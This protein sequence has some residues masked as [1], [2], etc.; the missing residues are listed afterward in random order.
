MSV[1]S[2]SGRNRA[3]RLASSSVPPIG[4]FTRAGWVKVLNAMDTAI[5]GEPQTLVNWRWSKLDIYR[6]VARR[7]KAGAAFPKLT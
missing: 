6:E 7:L 3:Q 5:F 1:A 2:V 4:A